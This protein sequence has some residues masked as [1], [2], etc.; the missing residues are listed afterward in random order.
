[1]NTLGLHFVVFLLLIVCKEIPRDTFEEPV[2]CKE[3]AGQQ[4]TT[5]RGSLTMAWGEEQAS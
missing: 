3:I 2:S 1:M 5:L 4:P